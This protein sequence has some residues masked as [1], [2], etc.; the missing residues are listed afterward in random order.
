VYRYTLAAVE[1][2]VANST[3][4]MG[5]L[6]W[7]M[8]N[9]LYGMQQDTYDVQVRRAWGLL[10]GGMRG[11]GRGT[12]PALRLGRG[13]LGRGGAWAAPVVGCCPCNS[14][15]PPAHPARS[16]ASSPRLLTPASSPASDPHPPQLTDS[17]FNYVSNHARVMKQKTNSRPPRPECK[18][19]CWVGKP[20]AAGN[21]CTNQPNVCAAWWAD[22]GGVG[23]QDPAW[24]SSEK[25][26]AQQINS[27]RLMVF[28]TKGACCRP[29]SGA[30]DAGCT[31]AE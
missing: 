5:S 4:M 17:T 29:G 6:F 8:S 21:T 23:T 1:N 28:P 9:F 11:R 7:R 26:M 25:A 3:F 16:P 2:A 13:L 27:G 14:L 19:G 30:F 15:T 10:A 24:R 22:F 20:D 12:G 31:A 18:L